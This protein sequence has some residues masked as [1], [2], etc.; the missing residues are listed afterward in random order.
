MKKA[1]A[2]LISLICIPGFIHADAPASSDASASAS[3]SEAFM[4]LTRTS[5][6]A[7]D[8][9][10]NTESLS[11]TDF[12]AWSPQTA[13][14]AA[15][16]MTSVQVSPTGGLGGK[17][18]VQI[19][20]AS[21]P[22]NLV[23]VDGRPVGG[24]S[25][26]SFADL[27]EIP[28]EAIDHIEVVRGGV[29][30]LYGPNAMGGVLNVITRRGTSYA[31]PAA[32]AEYDYGS[33][34]RNIFRASAG[35]K[36]GPLDVFAYGDTQH[37]DGFRQN[38]QADTFN[39]GGNFG[40]ELPAASKL[41]FDVSEFQSQIGVPGQIFI[42]TNQFDNNVE[43][44]ATT[45]DA[46]QNTDTKAL[47]AGYTIPLPMA[48]QMTVKAWDS[49]HHV[50]AKDDL[51]FID[52]DTMQTTKGTSAQFDLPLGLLV[53]G[54]FIHDREDTTDHVT[55]TNSFIRSEENYG[56]F[57]QDTMKWKMITLIPSGRF[58]HNSG[59]G[60]TANPRVQALADATP[61]LRFSGSSARSFRAPAIDDLYYPFS[62]FGTFD[63][64]NG[65]F[66]HATYT[67]TPDLL[68]ETAWTYDA[69]FELHNDAAS[70]KA[71]YFRANVKNLIQVINPITFNSGTLA[72]PDQENSQVINV[73]TA[74]RQGMEIEVNHKLNDYIK[75]GFNYTYLQNVGVLPGSPDFV[76]LAYSPR[77]K[78]NGYVT[79]SPIPWL[80]WTNSLR[81]ESARFAANGDTGDK[82][83]SMVLWDMKLVTRWKALEPYFQVNDITDRRYEEQD[84]YPLPGRTF[85]GGVQCHFE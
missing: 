77:H 54:D 79:W 20:G 18:T 48:S 22:Q 15:E 50:Q 9:P 2:L 69:G 11:S 65:R 38:S 47:N 45:P 26:P 40:L 57:A 3:G 71:T 35:G 27:T 56:F 74:R 29:S 21:T 75:D 63:E 49:E 4:T 66:I 12:S 13:G 53:G 85:I 76:D 78:A 68:P 24:I 59:F 42:P 84:G 8:L 25:F 83:G 37:E 70:F 60:D 61:W 44:Q 34:G 30:A 14:E 31:K 28:T 39:A 32:D 82:L 23:Q 72:D 6:P 17:E 36:N 41:T 81:Y 67:G 43:R 64:G 19:R 1:I 80:D 7:N 55:P 33:Y 52:S 10:T 5:V 62:D 51:D 16:R 58:D 46:Q 73:G